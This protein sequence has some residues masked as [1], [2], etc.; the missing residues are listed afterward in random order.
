[1]R[2][3]SIDGCSKAHRARGLCATHY[4][5]AHQPNRHKKVIIPCSTCGTP[6]LKDV[7][8]TRT[9]RYCSLL[10]R[11]YAR[12]GPSSSVLPQDHMARWVGKSSDW[13][14]PIKEYECGWCGKTSITRV[15]TQEHCSIWCKRKA[16]KARRRGAEHGA[17]GTYTW[18]QI[19]RLWVAFGKRCAYCRSPLEQCDLQAEHVQ[20][21]SKGGANNLSNLLP[22]C[23]PCNSDK[24][25]LSLSEWAADRTRR[26]LPA[27]A[28]AWVDDDPLYAHLVLAPSCR[29]A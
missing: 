21:I 18:T 3:C 12:F 6:T 25:D 8:N 22:S 17:N 29:A 4:N 27:V 20:P 23:G 7:A 19:V 28:T 10:C 2:E 24:R 1:M 11:D 5:Q 9:A 16:G 15:S 26:K 14:C 13:T